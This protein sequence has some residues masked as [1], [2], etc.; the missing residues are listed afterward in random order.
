MGVDAADVDQDGYN[1]LFVA[2]VDNEMFSLYRNNKDESFTDTANAHGIGQATRALSGWGLKFFDFDND[3][4]VDVLVGNNGGP[5]LLLKN[6]AAA[7]RHW[8]GLRLEGTTCNRDAIGARLT[9]SVGG[10]K[11]S[12]LKTSG[13]SYLSSHDPREVLG[14]GTA[15]SLDFLEIQW[16]APSTRKER[17]EKVPI[18]RY[19]RIVEGKGIVG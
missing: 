3:G 12:R 19:L 11:R 1:D 13:G 4:A 18:D 2:N 8:V 15:T 17:L 7:G 5:A 10:V 9:W 16:P 6:Q 14:L